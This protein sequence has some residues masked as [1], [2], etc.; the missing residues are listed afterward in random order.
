[1]G[2][3]YKTKDGSHKDVLHALNATGIAIGR[4]ILAII[5]NNQTKDGEVI[6][7]EVLVKYGAPEKITKEK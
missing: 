3:K 1:M 6:V 4:T 5:E 2:T 7:P